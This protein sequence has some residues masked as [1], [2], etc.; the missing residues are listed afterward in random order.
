MTDF[1]LFLG[2]VITFQL[3]EVD[4]IKMKVI[5]D[6]PTPTTL[7]EIRSFH[8]LAT[9]YMHFIRN[10]SSIMAP[11]TNYMKQEAFEWT[12]ATACAF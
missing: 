5:I 9:F 1:V 3:V 6:W 10:F 2:Y 12:H 11:I 7:F 8:G 4:P